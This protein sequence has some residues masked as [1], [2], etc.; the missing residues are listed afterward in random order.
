M[1]DPFTIHCPTRMAAP[2]D[3]RRLDIAARILCAEVQ[4]EGLQRSFSNPNVTLGWENLTVEQC[5]RIADKLIEA[6]SK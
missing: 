2:P 6:A 3:S 5:L 1:P 4:R